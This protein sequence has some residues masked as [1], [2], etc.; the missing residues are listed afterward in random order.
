MIYWVSIFV[1]DFV[2]KIQYNNWRIGDDIDVKRYFRK[3]LF[4]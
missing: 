3:F 2:F 1:L 4:R